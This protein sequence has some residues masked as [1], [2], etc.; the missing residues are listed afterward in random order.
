[1]LI[2]NLDDGSE[3]KEVL[4]S[5]ICMLFDGYAGLGPIHCFWILGGI[6]YVCG[7]VTVCGG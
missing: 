3:G 5:L 6:L 1:M 7:G 4:E 2:T